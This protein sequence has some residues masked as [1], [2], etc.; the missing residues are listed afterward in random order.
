MLQF[1]VNEKG[2]SDHIL[3]TDLE[4]LFTGTKRN[5]YRIMINLFQV[6]D[7]INQ[8]ESA[9]FRAYSGDIDNGRLQ[10]IS[11]NATNL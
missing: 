5:Y 8:L 9:D 1:L 10:M 2:G 11:F 3:K 4:Y 6:E 7:A